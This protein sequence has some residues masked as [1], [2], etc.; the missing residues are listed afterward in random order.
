VQQTS[1]FLTTAKFSSKNISF[2]PC[3]GLS[4]ENVVRAATDAK[5]SWYSGP[6][7]IE[8][9]ENSSP[10]ARALEFPLRITVGDIFRGGVVHPLSI[11]G[12][13][14]AGTLQVGDQILAMPSGEKGTI[15][16]VEVDGQ[17]AEWAVAG[18][19]AVLHLSDI[20]AIHLK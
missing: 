13:I 2:L 17:A 15:K 3:S 7:L 5:A 8:L 18:Q 6:T 20:D 4:G 12:R 9:L 1:A 16:G 14:D 11:S 19:I 10:A